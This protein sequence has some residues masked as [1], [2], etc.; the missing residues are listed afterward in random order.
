MSKT[1]TFESFSHTF[2]TSDPYGPWDKTWLRSMMKLGLTCNLSSFYDEACA[3][4]WASQATSRTL[5][6]ASI[7][8]RHE[9]WMARHGRVYKDIAEKERLFMIFKD[10]VEFIESFNKV[11]NRP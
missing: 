8:E 2:S 5:P 1:L 11:G 6:E 3:G 4:M 10:N 9:Q 7:S